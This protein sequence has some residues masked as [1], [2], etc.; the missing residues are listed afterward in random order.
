MSCSVFFFDEIKKFTSTNEIT[1]H[2]IGFGIVREIPTSLLNTL[3]AMLNISG[4]CNYETIF[5]LQAPLP[6][7][8]TDLR[9]GR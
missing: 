5:H 2:N 3:D 1:V 7:A 8:V 6:D 9:R 4:G